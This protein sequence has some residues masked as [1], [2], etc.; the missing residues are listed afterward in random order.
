MKLIKNYEY[1][2]TTYIV[3]KKTRLGVKSEKHVFA[4]G[5]ADQSYLW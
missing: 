1:Q 2:V 3:S 4:G 5:K